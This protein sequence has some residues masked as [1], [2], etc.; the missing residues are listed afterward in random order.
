[1]SEVV[2][3]GDGRR[4]ALLIGNQD[5]IGTMQPLANSRNNTSALAGLLCQNGFTVFR[6]TDLDVQ[7]FDTTIETFAGAAKGTK[8]ALVYYSG[9]GFAVGRRNWLVPVDARLSCTDIWDYGADMTRVRRQLLDLNEDVLSRLEGAGDQIVILDASRAEPVRGCRGGAS[10][11]LIKGLVRTAASIARLIIYATHDGEVA[12]DDAGSDTSLLVTAMMKRLPENPRHD[13]VT[14]MLE[15]SQEVLTLTNNKQRPS[16]DVNLRPEGCLAPDCGAAPPTA[17]AQRQDDLTDRYFNQLYEAGNYPA[18]L[19]LAE[20]L[21]TVAKARF[22]DADLNYGAALTRLALV[23]RALGRYA[24]AETLYRRVS[25]ITEMAL[26][27]YH[28]YVA[29][30]LDNLATIYQEQGEYGDAARLYERVLAI[31]EAA[32]GPDGPGTAT[33]LN[34]LAS[35]YEDQRRYYDAER[36]FKRALAIRQSALGPSHPTEAGALS[37]LARL[38]EVQSKYD[39]AESLYRRALA[40]NERAFGASHPGV[41][42][43]L[44]DLAGVYKAQHKYNDA[45][46]L[47]QRAVAVNETALG[48]NDPRAADALNN[49]AALYDLQGRSTESE[50][51][52]KRAVAMQ[53]AAEIPDLPWPPP[54]ASAW[55]V[56]PNEM[57]LGSNPTQPNLAA[58]SDRLAL[59]LDA[60]AYYQRSFFKVPDGFAMVTQVE[61]IRSDGTPETHGR[62]FSSQ[63]PTTFSLQGYLRRL[64]YADPGHYRL[65]VFVIT[66]KPFSTSNE[67][68]TRQEATD[69]VGR[70]VNVVP[71]TAWTQLYSA[72]H[73]CTA[74]IYEFK[75]ISATEPELLIPS[76]MPGRD[77]LMKARVWAA[78]A[79]PDPKK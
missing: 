31:N 15:V 16:I 35:V 74:L 51:L 68:L 37:N 55:D 78:L 25:S 62:W 63:G 67:A 53:R 18:A 22:G 26:G 19:V 69:L 58:I 45:E 33:A 49:L 4:V 70:G 77:H 43:S 28:P 24:E 34:N 12:L 59:A 10:P 41:A 39:E 36:L 14:A 42:A 5:Y 54:K 40:I 29:Q 52:V 79:T 30:A 8:T 27:S 9:H 76:P 7:S 56:I 46:A 32:L 3:R 64:L 66:D 61:R 17:A 72:Q 11:S 57:I 38:Y 47:Y 2:C 21:E 71:A 6:H 44:S 65:V 75:K 1:M 13:W 50:P 48:P 23:Y 73:R 20:R 60:G